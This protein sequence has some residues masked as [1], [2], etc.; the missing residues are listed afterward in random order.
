MT[1]KIEFVN[2]S[3][4]ICKKYFNAD[5]PDSRV[6]YVYDDKNKIGAI[7]KNGN[8]LLCNID[9]SYQTYKIMNE[10]FSLFIKLEKPEKLYVKPKD[11]TIFLLL[12]FINRGEHLKYYAK[13]HDIYKLE[14]PY[15]KH[16]IEFEKIKN[17]VS[18]LS[19]YMPKMLKD[20]NFIHKILL[21][22]NKDRHL[23]IITDFYTDEC[24]SLCTFGKKFISPYDYY[25]KNKGQIVLKSLKNDNF[26]LE[27]FENIMY[28]SE[29]SKFCNNFQVTLVVSLFKL[30]K[31]KK[32][33]DSSAGWGDRLIG[34]IALNIEYTGVDPSL[35]LKPLY[36]KIINELATEPRKYKILNVGIED[37]VTSTLGKYDLCFTSPPFFDLEVYETSNNSQSINKYKTMEDWERDFMVTLIEQNIKVLDNNGYF[38][39][40]I[41]EYKFTMN[42]L[43][44]HAKLK[45]IGIIAF[46]TP[47]IR[48]I[49]L[50]QK[51]N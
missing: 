45:Y 32:V 6:Y 22:F 13:Y 8:T 1:I 44:K 51:N 2:N 40:Y 19:S 29:E 23:N 34:A 46:Q 7:G 9:S 50:F 14:Y 47:K 35:C 18:Q 5:C 42:Y 11:A 38:A 31:A 41:P 21:D 33:F 16:F 30:L 17:I 28:N 15:L 12:G 26:D 39:I 48:K 43:K 10:I 49:F 3:I 36:Q 25:K 24:R 27:K 20:N 37:V 4:L